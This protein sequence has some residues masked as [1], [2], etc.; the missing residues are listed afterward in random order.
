MIVGRIVGWIFLLA[1]VAVFAWDVVAI[2]ISGE[3][4]FTPLGKI[5]AAIDTTSLQLLQA[6]VQR[7]VAPW[8][9]DYVIQPVLEAPAALDFFVLG[10]ILALIF[11]RRR[12][13]E[14]APSYE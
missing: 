7:H 12:P 13:K 6:G 8:L 14:T 11:R 2:V 3:L 4:A 9:W 5:W 1:A 10:A